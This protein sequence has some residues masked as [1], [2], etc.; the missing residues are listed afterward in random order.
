[1]K[2]DGNDVV[3]SLK[4]V[5]KIFVKRR[6]LR[7]SIPFYALE[8]INLDI[9][10]GERLSIIGESGSGKTT[11]ARIASGL[12]KPSEG[13]VFWFGR[14]ITKLKTKKF[15]ELRPKVQYIHQNPYA[16]INPSRTIFSVLADPLKR[17]E[18]KVDS[19][20]KKVADLLRSVGIVPPE[21]FFNKYPRH[22]SGGGLQRLAI[23]RAMIPKPE[24]ILADEI[25]S[26]IDMSFR[27]AIVKLLIELNEK[28]GITIIM[29]SHDIGVARYFS[30]SGG[31]IAV[32]LRGRI[33]EIGPPDAIVENPVHPYTRA[34]ILASPVANKK[35]ALKKRELLPKY[36]I[37]KEV[38]ESEIMKMKGC[39][40]A[41]FCPFA[42]EK[43]QEGKP[44]LTD[45]E[46]DGKHKVAC[47][48]IEEIPAWELESVG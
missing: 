3:M 18:G 46:K 17:Y 22:L 6:F 35:L 9:E 5:S 1:M 10:K 7:R 14:E 29:I 34:L 27:A 39:R 28:T 41:F 44:E 30:H 21:F 42:S 48:M 32:M 33:V 2:S 15:K 16:S 13:S 31:R 38:W 20:E 12:D 43:C 47:H 4:N 23:A 36:N 37:Q 26:M 40:Y 19:I 8:N 25:V 45:V 11:L 24:I